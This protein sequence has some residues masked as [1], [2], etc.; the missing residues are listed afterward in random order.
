MKT[1]NNESTREINGGA[2]NYHCPWGDYTNSSYV[3]TL[4][5]AIYCGYQHGY[6]GVPI[7]LIET[8]IY[9]NGGGWLLSLLKK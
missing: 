6:F 3:K 2:K 8:A 7:A 9:I 5:H 1:M 4:G